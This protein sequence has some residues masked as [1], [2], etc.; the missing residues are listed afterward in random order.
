MC[1]RPSWRSRR[2]R[3]A[4]ARKAL[5]GEEAASAYDILTNRLA[6]VESGKDDVLFLEQYVL[7][8][9]YLKD[10]DRFETFNTLLLDF[11][12]ESVIAGNQGGELSN[13]L[14]EHEKLVDA[15]TASRAEIAR[16][17]EE[18]AAL[19]RKLE[20]TG[21]LLGRVGFGSDPANLRAEIAGV[22][23]RLRQARFKAEESGSGIE[24]ARGN[25]EYM[26]KQY[27][28]R[29]GDYLSQPDN[30]RR[31]FDPSAPGEERGAA[32][33]LRARLLEEWIARLEQRDLLTHILA[34]Y[35]LR[36]I[37][38]DYC[39]PIHLQQLKKALVSREEY[40]RV[41][42]ILK[43]FPARQYSSQRI[44]ELSKKIRKTPR[45]EV[46]AVAI[47]FAEDFMRLRRDTRIMI[48]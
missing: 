22:E 38:H 6:F 9:N 32:A 43:Q 15:A 10:Q 44:E 29:L 13:A 36:N 34:S 7:L 18:R 12:R 30:A 17:E 16:L 23:K 40:K 14:Q 24:A 39:P 4:R 37:C 31:L 28:D 47:R 25:A 41:E 45:E 20:R 5:F 21:S 35:Q 2:I 1:S 11:L 3:L 48:G 26:A 33:D 46:R 8:G 19:T 27:L 42:D